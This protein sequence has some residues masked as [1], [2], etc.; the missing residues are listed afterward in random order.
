MPG[1]CLQARYGLLS[2]L[3]ISPWQVPSICR[4]QGRKAVSS[5]LSS[6][7]MKLGFKTLHQLLKDIFL[8]L[9]ILLKWFWN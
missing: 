7:D 6:N 2:L 9:L 5:I 1:S 8:K 4:K 3:Q